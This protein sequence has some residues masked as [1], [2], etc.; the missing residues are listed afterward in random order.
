MVKHVMADKENDWG[1]IW[2]GSQWSDVEIG[3]EVREVRI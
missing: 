2:G 1:V 3:G